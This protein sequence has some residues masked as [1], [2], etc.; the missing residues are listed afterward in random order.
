MKDSGRVDRDVPTLL[1]SKRPPRRPSRVGG[2]GSRRYTAS[3]PYTSTP[4]SRRY[5]GVALYTA[6]RPQR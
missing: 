2:G 4:S 6:W 3:P 5:T 1:H